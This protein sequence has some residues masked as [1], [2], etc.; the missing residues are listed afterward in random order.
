MPSIFKGS[1][2]FR[3]FWNDAAPILKKAARDAAIAAAAVVVAALQSPEFSAAISA[4][5][6]VIV[7]SGFA[8]IVGLVAAGRF[9]ADNRK[10]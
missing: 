10:G 5:F 2:S 4:H 7:A 3:L 9:L 6:G 8:T 1:P